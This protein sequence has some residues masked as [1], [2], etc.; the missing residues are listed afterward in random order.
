[1]IPA[2]IPFWDMANHEESGFIS[3]Q[4]NDETS[5][6]ESISM[7]NFNKGEQIFIYYGK[8]TAIEM[9]VNNGFFD[10]TSDFGLWIQLPGGDKDY[11]KELFI[12][13]GFNSNTIILPIMHE[14]NYL[15]DKFLAANRIFIM[16]QDMINDWMK[17]SSISELF[18]V[19][20]KFTDSNMEKKLWQNICIRIKVSLTKLIS[21]EK[22][23][24]DFVNE[25]MNALKLNSNK[26]I[27][28][29][30]SVLLNGYRKS[31]MIVLK[32]V[33]DFVEKHIKEIL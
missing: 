31:E 10:P 1:M 28:S 20:F 25:D 33:L 18:D 2:L 29:Y 19:N 32:N 3:T 17:K 23:N 6:V 27:K 9:L 22:T 24:T 16:D 26:N 15:S 21:D 7:R 8:R 11:R 13:A 5:S 4:F 30:V 12:K 14:P